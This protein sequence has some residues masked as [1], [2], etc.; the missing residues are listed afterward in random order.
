MDDRPEIEVRL[1]GFIE[2]LVLRVIAQEVLLDQLTAEEDN[3]REQLERAQILHGPR[4]RAHFA[5]LLDKIYGISPL[6]PPPEDW[7][8][9]VDKM[10]NDSKPEGE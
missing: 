7:N 8:A 10:L 2:A 6:D 3:W 9:I 5:E 4:I 1:Y